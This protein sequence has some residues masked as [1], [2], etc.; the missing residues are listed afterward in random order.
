MEKIVNKLT[1]CKSTF[2]NDQIYEQLAKKGNLNL[3][4]RLIKSTEV[5]LLLLQSI[6]IK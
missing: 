1:I 5:L 6:I 4:F 2:V 3:K